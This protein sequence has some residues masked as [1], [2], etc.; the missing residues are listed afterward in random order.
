MKK[1]FSTVYCREQDKIIPI[2]QM[3]DYQEK[4]FLPEYAKLSFYC[5]YCYQAPLTFVTGSTVTHEHSFFK[6]KNNAQHAS[7]CIYLVNE[8]NRQE[9]NQYYKDLSNQQIQDKLDTMLRYLQNNL[10]NHNKLNNELRT[11]LSNQLLFCPS[12]THQHKRIIT[13]ALSNYYD[14]QPSAYNIPILFYGKAFLFNTK[15]NSKSIAPY[16]VK[17]MYPN[18][19]KHSSK[20]YYTIFLNNI[21]CDF[22]DYDIGKP[23][24]LAMIASVNRPDDDSALRASLYNQNALKFE[25]PV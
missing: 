12:Q 21:Y 7:N 10:E 24:R 17:I 25:Q 16:C 11:R 19:H 4:F 20:K 13:R 23:C 6:T 5:P 14:T 8:A 3:L 9:I 1:E 18:Y 22:S 2:F 15:D